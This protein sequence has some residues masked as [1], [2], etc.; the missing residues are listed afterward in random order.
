MHMTPQTA[1]NI[2]RQDQCEAAQDSWFR[3]LDDATLMAM[4][5]AAILADQCE[6]PIIPKPIVKAS[7]VA[8]M[9]VATKELVRR[10]AVADGNTE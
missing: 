8:F 10:I 6:D 9:I 5:Q 7:L 1:Q 2:A 3:G 4:M